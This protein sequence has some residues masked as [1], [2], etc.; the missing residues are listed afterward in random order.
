M[1]GAVGVLIADNEDREVISMFHGGDSDTAR[2][3]RIPVLAIT[4]STLAQLV[5][6][7]AAGRVTLTV[8]L[9]ESSEVYA[10]VGAIAV[11]VS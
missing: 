3:V 2:R 4:P 9:N 11:Y 5:K 6:S 7:M 1:T 10:Q 8:E